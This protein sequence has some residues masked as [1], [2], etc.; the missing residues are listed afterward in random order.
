LQPT[1]TKHNCISIEQQF[2]WHLTIETV[3]EDHWRLNQPTEEY[4]KLQPHFQINLDEAGVL[5]SAG[6]LQIIGLTEVKKHEKNTQDNC[7]LIT[8]V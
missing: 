8:V 4:V 1:T 3:W 6:I 5:G 2:C 7:D